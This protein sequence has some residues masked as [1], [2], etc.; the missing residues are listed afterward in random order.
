[1]H[2]LTFEGE[3]CHPGDYFLLVKCSWQVFRRRRVGPQGGEDHTQAAILREMFISASS[4]TAPSS[5]MPWNLA[6]ISKMLVRKHVNFPENVLFLM[7]N[8]VSVHFLEFS[9]HLGEIFY[10]EEECVGERWRPCWFPTD[11]KH[12]FI[13]KM[14]NFLQ[15]HCVFT[16][17]LKVMSMSKI[18]FCLLNSSYLRSIHKKLV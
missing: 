1:M 18:S 13:S 3:Q 4:P 16:V 17:N 2:F 10:P 5:R 11:Y 7:K 15:K 8:T 6:V 14:Q 9:E 12:F